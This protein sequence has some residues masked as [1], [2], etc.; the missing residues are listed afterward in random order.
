MS[1]LGDENVGGLDVAV[2]YPLGVRG[3]QRVGNFNPQL[4]DFVL[5]QRLSVDLGLERLAIH[6]FHGDKFEAVLLA[7]VKNR[8]DVGMIQRRGGLC[9]AAETLQRRWIVRGFGG[10]KFESDEAV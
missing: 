1:A 9:F 10:K 8:A 7:N 4:E 5:G 2:N 6:K 3:V